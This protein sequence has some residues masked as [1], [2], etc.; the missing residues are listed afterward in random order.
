[1]QVGVGFAV[2]MGQEYADKVICGGKDLISL[3]DGVGIRGVPWELCM[4]R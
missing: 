1:M 2:D 4:Q 3:A